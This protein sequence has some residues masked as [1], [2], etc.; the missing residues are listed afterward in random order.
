MRALVSF[1][2]VFTLLL[3]GVS[4]S[5]SSRSQGVAAPPSEL[6]GGIVYLR[7]CMR[8]CQEQAV[9]RQFDSA[10]CGQYCTCALTIDPSR[11]KEEMAPAEQAARVSR[12]TAEAWAASTSD[13][14]G[15][16]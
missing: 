6:M 3:P 8:A 13:E 5:E 15:K 7:N 2:F 11:V 14:T 16:N 9:E 12:C 10:P 4:D 1:C